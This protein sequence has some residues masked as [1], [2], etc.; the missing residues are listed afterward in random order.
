[1][2]ILLDLQNIKLLNSSSLA[3]VIN[4]SN[5]NFAKISQAMY[6]FLTKIAYDEDN[7]SLSLDTLFA[8]Q[9]EIN[10][11]IKLIVNSNTMFAVDEY[12]KLTCESFVSK[13]IGEVKRLRLTEFPNYPEVGI[14]G[15]I[16]FDGEDFLVY[17]LG[18]GWVSLTGGSGGS[19]GGE[20]GWL[21]GILG[22]YSAPPV[23]TSYARYIVEWTVPATGAFVGHEGDMAVWDYGASTWSFLEPKPGN[24][25]VDQSD[26]NAIWIAQPTDPVQWIK[27][28][29][30]N[31]TLSFSNRNMVASTTIND[32]DLACNTAILDMPFP[33]SDITVFVNGVEVNVDTSCYFANPLFPTVPK[34]IGT[35]ESGDKLY[36]NGSVAG[37]QL[38]VT[39]KV[40]FLYLTNAMGVTGGS[41]IHN[42]MSGLQG[43]G[44]SPA[45][46]YHLTEDEYLNFISGGNLTYTNTA[47]M[48]TTVGGYL[49]GTSFSTPQ[50]LQEMFD[51]LL[52]PYQNPVMTVTG[53]LFTTYEVGEDLPIGSQTLS[54]SITNPTNIKT[55]P[56]A[57]GI[58]T[59]DIVGATFD[60]V[61]PITLSVSGTFD[62]TILAGTTKT[63]ATSAIVTLQGTNSQSS[64]FNDSNTIYWRHKRYWGVDAGTTIND[65][66]ILALVGNEFSTTKNKAYSIDGGG[67]YLY[68]CYPASWGL[69]TFTVG[70]LTVIFNLSVQ[71]FTNASGHTESYN[72]YRSLNI[73]NGIGIAIVVG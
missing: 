5:K 31:A 59:T 1:M 15:E 26:N 57:I 11:A 71:N 25:C 45:S 72:V 64:I 47:V 7:N 39:D 35:A 46:Y 13:S 44:G 33:D 52:Y 53:A 10:E 18:R 62:I 63:T 68:Y 16:I 42:E 21:S 28:S 19:G 3:S 17:I 65:A 22:F 23:P 40:T 38:Q 20:G 69:A 56:P 55:Q 9:L 73:Q 32:G 49:A 51:G 4:L 24:G 70:G 12:G 43:G 14:D 8:K 41:L 60:V 50:T 27:H 29:I 34:L 2:S 58:Q 66:G 37:F 30:G 67:K 61:N 6:S 54:Y 48:P 36:W